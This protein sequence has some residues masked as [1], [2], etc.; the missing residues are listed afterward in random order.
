MFCAK[1]RVGNWCALGVG[2]ASPPTD[3]V[4]LL[5]DQMQRLV[6]FEATTYPVISLYLNTQSDEHG[7]DHFEGFLRREFASRARTFRAGSPEAASFKR[8]TEKIREYIEKQLKPSANGLA[9]FACAG[10]GDFFEALQ[11]NA[12]VDEHRLYIYSQPHLY[13]LARLDDE[14]PRYA[15]LITDANFARIF[16]F[17]LGEKLADEKVKSKKV[18]RVKVG[19]W[20]QARYQRRVENAHK[21]HVRE[22][23]EALEHIVRDEGIGQVVIAGDP[24]ITPLVE[25]ELPKQLADKLVKNLRLDTK[26]PESEIFD[27]T[28]AAIREQDAVTDAEKVNRLFEQYRAGGLAVAGPQE[29]LEAL[30]NGQVDELLLSVALERTHDQPEPVEAVLAPEIP[31]AAGSTESDDDRP[32]L[33]ADLL[34]TKAK[35]ISAQVSFIEDATLLADVDGIGAFLRWRS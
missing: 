26:A 23:I 13:H 30:A 32:V 12:P 17:G 21:E 35:Q 16:V 5:E 7:R 28:L 33:L 24:A 8:D 27:A 10:A 1:A 22:A 29:T 4:Q 15:A 34:V 14:Y 2:M 31:D 9:I 3:S 6:D 19:G 25:Q 11:L 20:S 18:Q